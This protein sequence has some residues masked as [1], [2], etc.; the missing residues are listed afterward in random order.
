MTRKRLLTS[1]D[2]TRGRRLLLI[3]LQACLVAALQAS[4]PPKRIVSL[5]PNVTEMVYA[6]GAGDRLV[7]VSS[8]DNYPAEVRSLPRVGALLDPNLERIFALKPDLVI[9][10]GSQD[11]L[12]AQL[13]RAGIATFS[14][15]HG[16]LAAV[17]STI[18]E[19]GAT[20]GER[21]GADAVVAR[22]TSGIDDVRRRVAGRR[23]VR[24]LLVFGRERLA[25]RGIY[26]SGG[27]GF[28]H[29]MLTAAGGD[30]VF[31]DVNSESVQASTEQ[32]ISRQPEVILEVRAANEAFPS[33]DRD[34]ERHV[35]NALASVPAVKNGRVILLFDD[36]IVV[37]GPRVADGTRELARVLHPDAF[38]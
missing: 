2:T 8:Y 23:R 21:A 6:I 20:L 25:L 26:V 28:L 30:N 1:G 31:A 11:D 38:K 13:D 34:A 18:H 5:V 10:Y 19:L 3:C 24:T 36:R 29:D 14:Y 4:S 33:G 16:G 37:P 27:V 35:W 7:G 15:R 12:K 22:I 32:I 17:S 9:V